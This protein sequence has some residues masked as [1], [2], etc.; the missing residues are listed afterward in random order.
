M[1]KLSFH[2]DRRGCSSCGDG[3]QGGFTLIEMIVSVA[4]LLLIVGPLAT[5]LIV[6]FKVTDTTGAN[7]QASLNRDQ[8]SNQWAA[9]VGSVDA[10]GVSYS[11]AR[12]CG[13]AGGGTLFVT[14]NSTRL[15][16]AAETYVRRV[17]YYATGS[18]KTLALERRECKG[19]LGSLSLTDYRET[20]VADQ[21]DK[22]A[23]DGTSS[24]NPGIYNTTTGQMAVCTEFECGAN[25]IGRYE[26]ELRAAR[27]TFGVGTPLQANTLYS[28]AFT[29]V[30]G[31]STFGNRYRYVH[32]DLQGNGGLIEQKFSQKL[33]LAPG[34]GGTTE[35]KVDFKVK[36]RTTGKWLTNTGT[37]ATPVWSW[38]ATEG[39][40]EGSYDTTTETWEAKN[41]TVGTEVNN[42]TNTVTTY[43]PGVID[44]GGEYAIYT[45]ITELNGTVAQ[46]PKEFGGVNGFPMWMDWRPD[47]VVF[48]SPSGN[49]ANTGRVDPNT[50][51]PS[52]V[53][54]VAQG[55]A[56]AKDNPTTGAVDPVP[57]VLL[58]SDR[59][60]GT[61]NINATT[62]QNNTTLQ[63]GFIANWLRMSPDNVVSGPSA[64]TKNRHA[65]I[66]G[67]QTDV[68]KPVT[69][70]TISTVIGLKIR[71]VDISSH[72]TIPQTP[73]ERAAY[74]TYGLRIS[75]GAAV[76]FQNSDVHALAPFGAPPTPAAAST[77]WIVACSGGRGQ[78]HSQQNNTTRNTSTD[79]PQEAQ[80]EPDCATGLSAS[81][82]GGTGG[83]GGGDGSNNTKGQNGGPGG[84]PSGGG[85]AGSGGDGGAAS[86]TLCNNNKDGQ[87]GK[88]GRGGNGG[89]QSPT[90][91][92][93][94]R[95]PTANAAGWVNGAGQNGNDGKAG[96]GGGGS[97]GGGGNN[98]LFFYN[99]GRSGASGGDGGRGGVGGTGGWGG[100]SAIGI[101]LFGTR[102]VRIIDSGITAAAGGD[103]Q[104]GAQ[105]GRGG[106]GGAGGKAYSSSESGGN[107]LGAGGGGGGG[108]GAGGNGGPGGHSISIFKADGGG[109]V[110][111]TVQTAEAGASGVG[112]AVALTQQKA[113]DISVL[114][115]GGNGGTGGS[116]SP[117]LG[118]GSNT[119][120][121]GAGAGGPGG[122]ADTSSLTW[123]FIWTW[124]LATYPAGAGESGTGGA[125]DAANGAQGPSGTK[126]LVWNWASG[127]GSCSVAVP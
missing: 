30:N 52:P 32:Y 7:L 118:S 15:N 104:P 62:S 121:L 113:N 72:L 95:P 57:E 111:P 54:T 56:R 98:C 22:R 12:A 92:D 97:G 114:S 26:L 42:I 64:D 36:Q 112:T 71:Q 90:S 34:L 80:S 75:D 49:D 100:G 23:S 88:G 125:T 86:N 46:P 38:I 60:S 14:F 93:P 101:Y 59:Y 63:G 83:G 119:G 28:T 81:R 85:S 35:M 1:M 65:F 96:G 74:S 122:P 17:S 18:V 29:R 3:P 103:G 61:V 79:L 66:A 70:M 105:G 16:S 102:Q 68:T 50:G 120:R 40:N 24:I 77:T 87:P 39:W 48:V 126:C 67:T 43:T 89:T 106:N 94:A 44:A 25:I 91:Y 37:P 58:F 124:T 123:T 2:P 41:L 11:T 78:L 8:A 99:Y 5:A 82:Q 108:G 73:T 9:D 115:P 47:N 31:T 110:T 55:L 21:I 20:V 116:P 10:T 117:A 84:S 6:G 4:L 127:G 27:R 45:R 76:D 109:Y 51:I 13:S 107:S 69:G 19:L 53:Q 33:S